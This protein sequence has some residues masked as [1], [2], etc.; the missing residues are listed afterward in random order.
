MVG[1]DGEHRQGAPGKKPVWF[2]Q[3]LLITSTPLYGIGQATV[4][5]DEFV[6]TGR[7]QEAFYA[8]YSLS[9]IR[10]KHTFSYSS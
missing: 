8:E 1:V 6:A 2:G 4:Y 9:N 7:L 3:L 10:R 5:K